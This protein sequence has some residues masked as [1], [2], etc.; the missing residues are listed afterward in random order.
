MQHSFHNFEKM[1]Q[2][3]QK[4]RTARAAKT[5]DAIDKHSGEFAMTAKKGGTIFGAIQ[6]RMG[7]FS[8]SHRKIAEAILHDYADVVNMSARALA[9]TLGLSPSTVVRFA[10]EMG[11]ESYPKMLQDLR[12]ALLFLSQPPMKPIRDS[13]QTASSRSLETLL[14]D[15]LN[16]EIASLS[17]QRYAH[18]NDA[19]L[20]VAAFMEGVR[21]IYVVGARSSMPTASYA[22]YMFGNLHKSVYAVSAGADDRYERMEEVDER[23]ML[24]C[25]S[26]HRYFRETVEIARFSQKRGAFTVGITDY[27]IS[28]IIPHCDEVFFAP[29]ETPLASYVPT[30]ALLDAMSRALIHVKGDD[31]KRRFDK[32]IELLMNENIYEDLS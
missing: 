2:S 5:G 1:V 11:Y 27:Q 14:E 28:P 13:L 15:V 18:M 20:R 12:N 23:D 16:L 24:I 22:A 8:D 32:R 29:S 30:M 26:F 17:P 4:I 10:A 3:L 9:R 7:A 21:N 6:S 31:A 19:F 25:I